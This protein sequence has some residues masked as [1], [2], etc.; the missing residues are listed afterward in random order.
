[1]ANKF[2]AKKVGGYDSKVEKMVE[3]KYRLLEQ[4]GLISGLRRNF[5]SFLIIPPIIE[6]YVEE[7]QLKTKVKQVVKK[8]VIEKAAHYK[9]DFVFFDKETE[10]YVA[11][12][13]KS[14]AT[15]QEHSYPLRRKL[16]KWIILMHNKG[17]LHD[18]GDILNNPKPFY[19]LRKLAGM[20][21]KSCNTSKY[22]WRFD[23]IE[24]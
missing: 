8:K 7:V 6:E 9:C 5:H 20:L 16:F 1:M 15:K 4:A 19:V 13:V 24:M 14:W 18:V 2:G 10:E 21:L 22:P 17:I 11:L 12:E 3:Q 23:E